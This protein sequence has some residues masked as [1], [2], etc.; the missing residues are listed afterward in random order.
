[1]LIEPRF[2]A[3]RAESV[4]LGATRNRKRTLDG[5]FQT[6]NLNPRNISDLDKHSSF[7]RH[8]FSPFAALFRG[9]FQYGLLHFGQTFGSSVFP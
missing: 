9:V 3:V 6:F 1:M 8:F 7:A 5:A 4:N 2:L